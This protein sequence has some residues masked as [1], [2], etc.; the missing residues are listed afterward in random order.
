M[1]CVS[2]SFALRKDVPHATF[3]ERKATLIVLS[4]ITRMILCTFAD[5]P[6]L[7]PDHIDRPRIDRPRIDRPLIDVAEQRSPKD[8]LRSAR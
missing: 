8:T 3:V 5:G 6:G 2:S 4:F 1:I 7:P